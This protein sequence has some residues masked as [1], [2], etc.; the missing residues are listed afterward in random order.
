HR[1]LCSGMAADDNQNV[2]AS[3]QYQN[4]EFAGAYNDP[5]ARNIHSFVRFAADGDKLPTFRP[6]VRFRNCRVEAVPNHVTD[7]DLGIQG[8]HASG[9]APIKA[10]KFGM[11]R[12]G[13]L[14]SGESTAIVLPPGTVVL[15]VTWVLPAGRA[16]SE[17]AYRF[18]LS[19]G[20]DDA[21][22]QL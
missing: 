21:R 11:P 13:S 22:R 16:P 5:A 1:Y 7:W 18:E 20:Y 2:P 17:R 10:L 19:N 8:P 14:P 15:R 3:I 12:H 6:H 9:N 4:C